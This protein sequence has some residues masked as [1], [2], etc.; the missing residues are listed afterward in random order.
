[1]AADQFVNLLAA[2]ALLEMMVTLGLGV[3]AS[4]RVRGW[5][6]ARFGATGVV[7]K[8]PPCVH[9]A[10]GL[11]LLF[12]GSPNGRGRVSGCRGV[13]RRSLRSSVH[14]DGERKRY[15]F[16]RVDGAPGGTL[17]HLSTSHLRYAFG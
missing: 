8:L 3:K 2:I 17:C 11:L 5:Q 14:I 15:A 1:M 4:R 12:H 6:T 9:G 13:P 16:R 7:S 10:L